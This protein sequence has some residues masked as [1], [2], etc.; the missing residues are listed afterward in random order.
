MTEQA[1]MNL[2]WDKFKTKYYIIISVDG[3]QMME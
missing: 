1:Y 2:Q 3:H